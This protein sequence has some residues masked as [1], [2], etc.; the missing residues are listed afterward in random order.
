MGMTNNQ[1]KLIR[2]IAENKY[3]DAKKMAILCCDEDTTQKNH[4]QVT[5][6][7]NMLVSTGTIMEL[8]SNLVGMTQ[9]EDVS[10]SF[11]EDR[12]YLSPRE[13]ALF[14]KI[15]NMN[16]A[17]LKLMEMGIPYLNAI[18]LTGIS[19]TGKTT[20]GRYVAYKLNLPFMYIN[21]SYL[22]DSYMGG[23]SKNI[24]KVFDYVK[25]N[26]CVLM[27]DEIDCIAQ[28]RQGGSSG[29][30]KERN[31]TTISL[32]QELDQVQND[33]IIIS[34]TNVP[35]TIDHAVMRRFSLH[36][37]VEPLTVDESIEMATKYLATVKLGYDW[38]D[39]CKAIGNIGKNKIQQSVLMN[40]IITCISDAV[41]NN[42][43]NLEFE[44]CEKPEEGGSHE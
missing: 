41:I 36:H 25:A 27:L 7:R 24:K 2:A 1:L 16:K 42:R 22:I 23:T 40:F 14:E 3:S 19:G 5:R 35:N 12:Y 32:L 29:C 20:F 34:A 26:K 43:N 21:F 13:S 10:T 11:R 6:Y 9:L 37:V 44:R 8:P 15:D 4:Y 28:E 18:M 39:M 30:D 31:N 38:M 33:T 17:S